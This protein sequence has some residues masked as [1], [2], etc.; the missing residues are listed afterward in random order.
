MYS[1]NSIAGDQMKGREQNNHQAGQVPKTAKKASGDIGLSGKR[2]EFGGQSSEEQDGNS[3]QQ[4]EDTAQNLIKADQSDAKWTHESSI[5]GL[6][7]N[8]A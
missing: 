5:T 7:R 2:S 4:S 8:I 3:E 1:Q 6:G